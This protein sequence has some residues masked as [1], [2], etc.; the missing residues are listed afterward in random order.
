[1]R[2]TSAFRHLLMALVIG[3]APLVSFG[4]T[5]VSVGVSITGAPPPLPVYDQ[6]PCPG[7]GY[8]WIPGYWAYDDDGYYWVAGYWAEPP[9]IGFLWTPGYW[10]YSD[11]F[12]VWN[13]GYWA[14]DVGFYGGINYGFG[15]GGIGYYGGRWDGSTFY[16]NTA[17]TNVNRTIVHNT[18]VQRSSPVITSSRTSFNGP[19]GI[20]ARPTAQQRVAMRE[21]HISA[22]STQMVHQR[23]AAKSG[24]RVATVNRGRATKTTTTNVKQQPTVNKATT[25]NVK[26]QP[27]VNKTAVTNIKRQPTVNKITTTK[28]RHQP[29]VNTSRSTAARVNNRSAKATANVRTTNRNIRTSSRAAVT[30]QTG[31]QER[32]VRR[33]E[34][35]RV[36]PKHRTVTHRTSTPT[37]ITRRETPVRQ[38]R[39]IQ[40]TH[41]NNPVSYE[42]RAPAQRVSTPVKQR[43]AAPEHRGQQQQN[44][45]QKQKQQQNQKH[46]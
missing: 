36:A 34:K 37:A 43:A 31:N 2:F 8:I 35:T 7:D 15:Y 23:D 27:S 44:Q 14:T 46:E 32:T 33:A 24:K 18:Y 1:M 41:P 5:A 13:T 45:K 6:P 9:E 3:G 30:R 17:V 11:G 22:T 28:V 10:V 12:Y 20:T 21:R 4:Q 25:T 29:T 38:N 16:Y 19:G 40:T 39:V 42:H 26:Q